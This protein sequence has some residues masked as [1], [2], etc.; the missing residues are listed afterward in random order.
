MKS[1]N[2]KKKNNIIRKFEQ[3]VFIPKTLYVCK[4]CTKEFMDKHFEYPDHSSIVEDN[5][6]CY[7]ATTNYGVRDK[8]TGK[9]CIVVQLHES[10]VDNIKNDAEEVWSTCTHEAFH[11]A[12]EILR[13]CDVTL[14]DSSKETYAYMVGWAGV[15]IFKTVY[16][17]K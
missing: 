1:K 11:V 3:P 7:T 8:A 4:Y 10:I 9:Y 5:N 15:C 6:D 13:Y 14:S 2:N 17:V 12:D 16:D